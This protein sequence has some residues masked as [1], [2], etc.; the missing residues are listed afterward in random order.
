MRPS[1]VLDRN[2]EAVRA[3][4]GRY[5]VA[6]PRVFGS[7]ADGTDGE[8]SDLDI[9]V[10]TLPRTT[11]FHLGGLHADLEEMLGISVDLTTTGGL[12]KEMR[13]EILRSAKPL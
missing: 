12:R 6:N 1:E 13:D 9:L 7:V 3:L 8:T 11:L 10:D 5:P 2:R 4:I